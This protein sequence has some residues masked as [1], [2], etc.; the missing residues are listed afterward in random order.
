[1]KS[2]EEIG[3]IS[4]FPREV[5][6]SINKW[7]DDKEIVLLLG[8][9]QVGKT[10]ILYL[11][12]QNLIQKGI[13]PKNIFYF[14]LED[15]EM[16]NLLNS[17]IK[18]FVHYIEARKAKDKERSY[19]F[20]DEIQY[21]D[22][23]SNLLKLLADH[24]PHLKIICTG[25]STLEIRRKF[26]DSLVG[27]KVVFD[28]HPL[29]FREFLL[30]QGKQTLINILKDHPLPLNKSS[31]DKFE[32]RIS[33]LDQ[34][35]LLR[36]FEEYVIFGGY[37]RVALEKDIEKKT[38]L[39]NEIYNTYVRKDINQLFD[40]ENITA[41]NNLIKLLSFQIG[42]LVNINELSN[43]LGINRQT[44]E[45]YLF[46]L[47]NTFIIKLISPFFT[48]KRKEIVKSKKVFFYDLGL[49]NQVTRN[50]N[51]LDLRGDVGALIENFTFI[52]IASFD[53]VKFWRT[54]NGNEVDFIIKERLPVE[55]KYQSMKGSIIPV[56]I[57]YFILEYNPEIA[58][59]ITKDY[60]A[61]E[62][63]NGKDI[64]FFPVWM[65]G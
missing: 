52:H 55:V 60:F 43:T 7:I 31:F 22:N 9:R 33:S 40:I 11:L 23:P 32:F 38:V 28:I 36:S 8:S 34:L 13:H 35:E 37:P 3:R 47:E 63:K 1:M 2:I 4:L 49:R 30:F 56:G 64:L 12:I 24:Y 62:E 61:K 51:P 50:T 58:I 26:K 44:V 6:H 15:F 21:L 18:D 57:R 20:I 5:I 54:K 19:V 48:N 39:I 25:S 46:I 10:S 17:G 41:F 59:V 45:K 53:E 16:L 29:S 14:D 65:V 27:R 42:N